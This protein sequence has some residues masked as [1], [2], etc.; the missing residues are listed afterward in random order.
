MKA[1]RR[2]TAL[3]RLVVMIGARVVK[4][5]AGGRPLKLGAAGIVAAAVAGGL[6]AAKAGSN[7]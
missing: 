7:S 3:G 5:K 2:H 1:T 6:M 4:K